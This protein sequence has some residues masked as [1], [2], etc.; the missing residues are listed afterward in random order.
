MPVFTEEYDKYFT[1]RQ[2]ER[3]GLFELLKNNYDIKKALYFGSHIH[4]TPSL[5]FPDV[6]YVDSLFQELKKKV[7]IT[8]ELRDNP[9]GDR[10]FGITDPH[11]YKISF[12]TKL[13]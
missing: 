5:V 10:S 12:F 11:G 13:K 9:W 4:I 8:H 2:F 1:S 3:M 7:T 6:V